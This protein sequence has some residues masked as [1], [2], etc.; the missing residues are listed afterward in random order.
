MNNEFHRSIWSISVDP[1]LSRLSRKS[2]LIRIIFILYFMYSRQRSI[3]FTIII[4]FLEIYSFS[5]Y[6]YSI[7]VC[8][9]GTKD[10]TGLLFAAFVHRNHDPP[11]VPCPRLRTR[12]TTMLFDRRILW[13]LCYANNDADEDARGESRWVTCSVWDFREIPFNTLLP[14]SIPCDF[15]LFFFF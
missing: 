1:L 2:Q 7:S 14:S 11:R 10:C 13:K 12:A 8:R 3:Y 5:I 6:F 15:F 9:H 4:D